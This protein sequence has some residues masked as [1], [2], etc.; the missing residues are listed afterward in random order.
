VRM[1]G[2]GT[3]VCFGGIYCAAGLRIWVVSTAEPY[4]SN[5]VGHNTH[6]NY[7]PSYHM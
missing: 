7:V 5:K 3:N 2:G 6:V 4:P 1:G